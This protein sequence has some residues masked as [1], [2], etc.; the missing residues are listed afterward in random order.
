M[1]GFQLIGLDHG[2]FAGLFELDPDQ[3]ARRGIRRCVADAKPG[4]PCRVSLEDADVG[5]ELLLLSYPHQ[6]ADSPY[7]AAG[8]VF[9]RRGA[10][11]ARLPPGFV[12]DYVASRLMSLRAYDA[13][14]MMVAAEVCEGAGV[15]D[16]LRARFA[17][18]AVAYVHLHNARRGCY[19]CLARRAPEPG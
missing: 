5:E 3:L 4:Y 12:P 9:V 1:P 2:E 18:P 19:S 7:R 6:A 8:P 10:R 17:D 16:W 11:R 14:H 13:A 15:A